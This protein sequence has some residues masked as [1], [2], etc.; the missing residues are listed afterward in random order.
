MCWMTQ[1]A[2]DLVV[3]LFRAL[4]SWNDSELQW[5]MFDAFKMHWTHNSKWDF[6]FVLAPSHLSEE[7]SFI[8]SECNMFFKVSDSNHENDTGEKY[9]YYQGGSNFFCV[10][11]MLSGERYENVKQKPTVGHTTTVFSQRSCDFIF[12]SGKKMLSYSVILGTQ[13]ATAFILLT[14]WQPSS[15][16]KFVLYISFCPHKYSSKLNIMILNVFFFGWRMCS[17][18]CAQLF[19]PNN[20]KSNK[21]NKNS[22][23]ISWFYPLN[24]RQVTLTT[25]LF[26]TC[27]LNVTT[28]RN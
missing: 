2:A 18:I 19:I 12:W 14:N 9:K 3:S 13:A 25:S 11:Q 24:G 17:Q 15:H 8:L 1:L 28:D 27:S 16:L 10:R 4:Q 20:W 6:H 5:L 7:S 23:T 21:P 22:Y 26:I